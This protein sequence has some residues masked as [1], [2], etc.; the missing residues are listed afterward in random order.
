MV[1]TKKRT[2]ITLHKRA[3]GINIPCSIRGQKILK[4]VKPGFTATNRSQS[5]PGP[6]VKLK[7][8]GN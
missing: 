1:T 8:K 4:Q 3:Q 7:G 6:D 2:F 5:I